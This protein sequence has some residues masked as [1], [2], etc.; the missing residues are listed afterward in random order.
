MQEIDL[1]ALD[2][3]AGAN[4]GFW[5]QLRHPATN[6]P[7]PPRLQLLGMDSDRYRAKSAELM[8]RRQDELARG[9]RERLTPE[10]LQSRN[11]E[12]LAEVTAGWEGLRLDGE[13][14]VFAPGKA[15]ELYTRWPWIY[16]Q[17]NVAV[18]DR[19]NFLPGSASA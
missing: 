3:R 18:T 14:Y 10:E 1:A 11:I 5:L 7:I 17:A 9:A 6:V 19:A 16:E 8:R 4:Q 13:P 12:L 15:A 2:T